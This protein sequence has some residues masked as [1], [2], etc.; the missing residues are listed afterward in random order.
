[1]TTLTFPKMVL[2]LPPG[3][4]GDAEIT[5]FTVSEADSKFTAMRA[6]QHPGSYVPEGQY[7][8]LTVGRTLMMTDTQNEKRT[9]RAVVHN[10]HGHVF[11]AGLGI[12]MILH[13]IAAKPEVTKI[14]V[15]EKS[16]GVIDLVKGTL[17]AK[18]EVIQGDIFEYKPA[19]GTKF[20][21][22]YFDIWPDITTDN[23][24]EMTTLHRRFRSSLVQGGWMDSWCRDQLKSQKRREKRQDSRYGW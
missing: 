16:Q 10:A 18:V 14:T 9:N 6:F 8:Q 19:K 1:M 23:L 3:K 11:I 20:S 5:H 24:P 21:T 7:A 15:L 17:P 4:S 12:G 22:I 13:P 2:I